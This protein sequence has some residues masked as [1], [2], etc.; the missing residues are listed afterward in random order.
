MA[1]L[2]QCPAA[3]RRHDRQ[4]CRIGWAKSNKIEHVDEAMLTDSASTCCAMLWSFGGDLLTRGR[5]RATLPVTSTGSNTSVP[6]DSRGGANEDRTFAE[7]VPGRLLTRPPPVRDR[8]HGRGSCSRHAVTTTPRRG[9]PP[10]PVTP[11]RPTA[12]R[13]GTTPAADGTTAPA[14]RR[15]HRHVRVELLRREAQGGVRRRGRLD[16]HRRHDQHRRPQHVPGEL[17]H[18]HPATRRRDD[19]VRRLPDA[20]LRDQ[21]CRRRRLRRV[22]E[23]PRHERRFQ[24]RLDG[25]RRQAVLRAVLLLPMG[26]ALPP[27]PVRRE[28]VRDPDDLGRVQGAVRPDGQPTVSSRW[29]PPT[30]AGGRRWA[31]STCSTCASTATTSTSR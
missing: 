18:L 16:R 13:A 19:V 30:T 4:G 7:P 9:R 3:G 31:C 20:G 6:P 14:A 17:Q 24:E 23:P 2:R 8:G 11:P 28:G 10:P 15:R 1:L 25:A 12:P 27:E 21:G 5:I 22:G 29:P 26:R